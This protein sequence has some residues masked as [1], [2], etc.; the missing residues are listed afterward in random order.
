MMDG[1][2]DGWTHGHKTEGKT[3]C[4]PPLH[5][6]GI[7]NEVNEFSYKYTQI[8]S[9]SAVKTYIMHCPNRICSQKN[10]PKL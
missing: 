1:Q 10:E 5:V 9:S 7:K 6:G 2:T 4:P 8:L 3:I